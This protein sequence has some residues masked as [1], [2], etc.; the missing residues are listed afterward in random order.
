MLLDLHGAIVGRED[1]GFSVVGDAVGLRVVGVSV[2]LL[3]PTT[4]EA[5]STRNRVAEVKKL[6]FMIPKPNQSKSNAI[7][8]VK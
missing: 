5:E 2:G 3:L 7:L 4:D 8:L 1:V 6:N